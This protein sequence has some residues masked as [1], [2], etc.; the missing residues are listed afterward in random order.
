[1]SGARG[2]MRSEYMHWAKNQPKVR[3]G[4]GSSEVANFQ[5]DRLTF[6]IADLELDGASRHRYL[7]LRKAIADRHGVSPDCVV[8]ADGTSM[9][10][11]LA[12]ATLIAPGDEV[13]VEQPVYEPL[14]AAIRFLGAE[15]I[16]FERRAEE[17][18]RLDPAR[19]ARAATPRTSLIVITNLHNPSSAFADEEALAR[20]GAIGPRILVDEVYLDSAFAPRP[21]SAFHVGRFVSTSSLTKVYGLSG[22][23]CGWILAE[24]ELAEKMWRLNELFGVAQAHAAE[25]LGC[26]AFEHLDRIAAGT[27]ALLQRNRDIAAAFLA[28]RNDLEIALPE[29]GITLFPRLL[30]GDVDS[31]HALLLS[32]YDTSIVPGKWFEMPQHFRIGLGAPTELFEEGL[33]RLGAALDERR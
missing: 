18:F 30:G 6:S 3:F 28:G 33:A 26:I 23:R 1:M 11:F 13:L 8:T 21:R 25:R 32:R 9:A 29:A 16:R 19:V 24:P 10:N 7:P 22:I 15:I 14:L 5:L 2:T 27:P 20:I 12:L 31:L 4:L 17:G